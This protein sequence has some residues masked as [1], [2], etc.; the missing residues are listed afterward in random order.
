MTIY[1]YFGTLLPRQGYVSNVIINILNNLLISFNIQVKIW[2]FIAAVMIRIIF[3][4]P[5]GCSEMYKEL[6]MYHPTWNNCPKTK[7]SL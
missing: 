4:M 2:I 5:M 7:L 1:L 6:N 3:F